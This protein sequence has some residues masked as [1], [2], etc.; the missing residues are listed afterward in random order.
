MAKFLMLGKY[1]AEA[2]KGMAAERTGKAVKAM[3]EAPSLPWGVPWYGSWRKKSN[4][5][6]GKKQAPLLGWIRLSFL[7]F[8]DKLECFSQ[9]AIPR[10]LAS[11]RGRILV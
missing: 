2:V 7:P 6:P 8:E 9:I 1:S 3:E 5:G 4:G 10:D 11:P